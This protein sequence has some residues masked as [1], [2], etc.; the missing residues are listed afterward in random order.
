MK[1]IAL[2]FCF[3]V[4]VTAHGMA[5]PWV[6]GSRSEIIAQASFNPPVAVS[7][8]RCGHSTVWRYLKSDGLI[9]AICPRGGQAETRVRVSKKPLGGD[10]IVYTGTAHEMY[11]TV[12]VTLRKGNSGVNYVRA[13][14]RVKEYYYSIDIKPGTDLNAMMHQVRSVI[15]KAQ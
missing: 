3:L 12:A 5:N 11:K 13:E 1:K 8:E 14:F 15:D 9:E 6:E 7:I 10:Y 2:L 4:P